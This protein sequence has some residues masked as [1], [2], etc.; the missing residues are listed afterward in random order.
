[1][2]VFSIVF[3]ATFVQSQAASIE[4]VVKTRGGDPGPRAAVTLTQDFRQGA[5]A[6]FVTGSDGRFVFPAIPPGQYRLTAKRNGYADAEYGRRGTNGGGSS[7]TVPAGAN[8]KD[9]NLTM[10][11]Y[12]AI[13]GRITDG[14]GEPVVAAVVLALRYSYSNGRRSLTEMKAVETNDR[15]EYRL[16]WLQPGKYYIRCGGS[17]QVLRTTVDLASAG[18]FVR[19]APPSAPDKRQ[20]APAYFPG[21]TDPQSATPVDLT[22]GTDY[23]GVDFILN[24]ST[25]KHVRVKIAA[26]NDTRVAARLTLAPRSPAGVQDVI[27]G[28]GGSDGQG[29]FPSV[30]PGSYILTAAG[31]FPSGGRRAG[32]SELVRRNGASLPVDVRDQD[33]DVTLNLSPSV[34]F[35]GR[36]TVDGL[37]S[38]V[39]MDAH[40]IVSLLA[41]GGQTGTQGISDF[42]D[43]HG[44]EAFDFSDVLEGEYSVLIEDIPK[45][46]YLKS[47]R[48]GSTDVLAD[49]LHVDSQLNGTLEIVLGADG[50]T[51]S[52]TVVDT[53][54]QPA[55]NVSVT[56]VPDESRRN[57]IDLHKTISTDASGRFTLQ[58]VAPGVYTVFAWEDVDPANL[59]DSDF[60]RR[61]EAQGRSIHVNENGTESVELIAIPDAY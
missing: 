39:Q 22:P 37:R 41:P 13:S 50:G 47:A 57:R 8:L 5:S 1:M 18:G 40:P 34:D 12:G 31:G 2:S 20:Y 45:D 51:V 56:L 44:N 60:I 53:R 21:T 29:Q 11:A 26:G 16:F 32:V 28:V 14:D 42:A 15:G 43:F 58:G 33:V 9:V 49:G 59:Y 6:T 36:V 30:P 48:F 35:P 17:S 38:G 25:L 46:T 3:L 23:G 4:G 24:A 61:F 10:T 54:R 19:T 52:G 55:A 27:H 7:I